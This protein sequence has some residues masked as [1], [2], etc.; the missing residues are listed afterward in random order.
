MVDEKIMRIDDVPGE[1]GDQPERTR[2]DHHRHDGEP[3]EAIGEVD[4]VA[5]RDDH[6]G[7]EQQEQP[8]EIGDIAVEERQRQRRR[9]RAPRQLHRQ[10]GEEGDR[11]LPRKTGAA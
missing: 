7:P 2:R 8:A 11:E 5:E 1:I 4:G 9:R 6:E 10:T 3:V